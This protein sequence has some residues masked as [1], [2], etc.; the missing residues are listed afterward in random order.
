MWLDKRDNRTHCYISMATFNTFVMLTPTSTSKTIK[1]GTYCCV[2]MVT[3][4]KQT[5]YTVTLHVQYIVKLVLTDLVLNCCVVLCIVCFVLF[6]VLF[7]CK[8]VLPKGDNPIAVNKYIISNKCHSLKMFINLRIV[9]LTQ[10]KKTAIFKLR[11]LK[12]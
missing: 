1:K 9:L 5:R 6:Y 12:Y 11:Q 10:K 2:S 3:M 4:V 7:V 8:C